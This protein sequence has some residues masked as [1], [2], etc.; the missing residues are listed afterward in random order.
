MVKIIGV[1]HPN[2]L[3]FPFSFSQSS[4][5]AWRP[6]SGFLHQRSSQ[7]LGQFDYSSKKKT[8]FWPIEG[9]EEKIL[10]VTFSAAVKCKISCH[11]ENEFN[12]ILFT[13]DL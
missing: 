11:S 12:D 10:F 13:D 9:L 4:S 2:E 5:S 8:N 6:P 1:P 3:I 7:I